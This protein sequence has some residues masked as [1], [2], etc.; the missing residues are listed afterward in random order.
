MFLKVTRFLLLVSVM[1]LSVAGGLY[2]NPGWAE[3]QLTLSKIAY[4]E[5]TFVLLALLGMATWL[6]L[7]SC[8]PIQDGQVIVRI[9]CFFNLTLKPSPTLT[10]DSS[11][12]S[13]C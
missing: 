12:S 5:F 4:C 3:T 1:L 13:G 8:D 2:G 10:R 6:Y 7:W 9:K 11:T